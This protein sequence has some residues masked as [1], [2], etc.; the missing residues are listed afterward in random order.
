[1]SG[2]N[3]DYKE[4]KNKKIHFLLCKFNTAFGVK[5]VKNR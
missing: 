3:Q 4:R 2:K 1:M 5:S